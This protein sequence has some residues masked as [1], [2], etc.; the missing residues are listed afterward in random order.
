MEFASRSDMKNALK[1]L[2]KTELSGKRISVY[3]VSAHHAW[4]CMLCICLSVFGA[5][6]LTVPCGVKESRVFLL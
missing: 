4:R 3:E 6:G 1:K 5:G 2:D